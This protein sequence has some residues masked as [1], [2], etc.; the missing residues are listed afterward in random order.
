MHVLARTAGLIEM[1]DWAQSSK[2][3][4]E[5]SLKARQGCSDMNHDVYAQLP[6]D[7]LGWRS[8]QPA[9]AGTSARPRATF[10]STY[11][12]A[13]NTESD[14]KALQ[15]VHRDTIGQPSFHPFIRLPPEL[16]RHIWDLALSRR[17]IPT[18]EGVWDK[19]PDGTV[20]DEL[21]TS[22]PTYATYA[23]ERR[24]RPPGVAH[25]CREGRDVA[26]LGRMVS[27]DN[28]KSILAQERERYPIGDSVGYTWFDPERD[29]LL[30]EL[31][32]PNYTYA[33]TA[34][35]GHAN[36][37]IKDLASCV[38]HVILTDCRDDEPHCFI[39]GLFNPWLF[40]CLETIGIT[41][42][43]LYIDETKNY[44]LLRTVFDVLRDDHDCLIIHLPEEEIADAHEVEQLQRRL[45]E[46]S[47]DGE[48]D[49]VCKWLTLLKEPPQPQYPGGHVLDRAGNLRQEYVNQ[50]AMRTP[51]DGLRAWDS[52]E[53]PE[54]M[55]QDDYYPNVLY[56][57]ED[58]DENS[59]WTL[60]TPPGWDEY[61]V[62]LCPKI[63]K[64]AWAI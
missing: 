27:A 46:I 35:E 8:C 42:R 63:Y 28:S 21:E 44:L 26:G 40:P 2:L 4:V 53:Y 39:E 13:V 49:N 3:L 9:A 29:T 31:D 56:H 43:V 59:L 61:A 11:D 12:E 47:A 14:G 51:L 15:D 17:I 36:Q 30:V 64:V 25:A 55:E 18:L 57:G 34:V 22:W 5:K 16:R 7:L 38:R 19:Q 41:T 10:V 24:H 33:S 23:F 60:I 1:C 50:C 6:S 54:D 20:I 48:I 37:V 45:R 32:F 62:S 58:P 52:L